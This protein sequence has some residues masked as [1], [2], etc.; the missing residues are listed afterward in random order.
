MYYYGLAII[1][2]PL[3]DSIM[4]NLGITIF[5]LVCGGYLCVEIVNQSLVINGLTND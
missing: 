2:I 4:F 1:L 5:I 3:S